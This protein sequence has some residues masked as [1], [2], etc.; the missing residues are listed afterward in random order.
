MIRSSR[1][2]SR[3]QLLGLGVA[4]FGG[5]VVACGGA[6]PTAKLPP[7]MTIFV[8]IAISVPQSGHRTCRFSSAFASR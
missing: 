1:L 5:L 8:M 2:T 3:R 7:L 4:A 6:A